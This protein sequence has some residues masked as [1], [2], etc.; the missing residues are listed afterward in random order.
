MITAVAALQRVDRVLAGIVCL[1]FA[2]LP[3]WVDARAFAVGDY[4]LHL[5]CRGS[6]GP[7]VVLDV[8]LGGSSLEWTLVVRQL[9]QTARVCTYDRAGYGRSDAGPLPRTSAR[10]AEELHRLLRRAG[11]NA[12][13]ILVGHSF[14]GYNM[15]LFARRYRDTVAGLVL[16]D[17]SHPRQVERFLAPPLNLQTAPSGAWGIVQFREP[18]AP[19]P[20]LPEGVR[21]RIF[22]RARSAKSRR[23]LGAELLSFRD[24]GRQ[25]EAASG[26]AN[27]PLIVITR[28]QM[29]G[30]A[31]P[32]RRLLERV[33]LELQ[34]E[35]AG[36]SAV[37]AHLVARLSGHHIH[38]EQPE[39]VRYA[40]ALLVKRYKVAS[41]QAKPATAADDEDERVTLEEVTWLR[42]TL[43]LYPDKL[44]AHPLAACTSAGG[45]VCAGTRNGAP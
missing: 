43:D 28:G 27:L 34:I 31:T 24:S 17:A 36:A 13:Y 41:G 30:E 25:L 12:P 38:I 20:A 33:W 19:H 7:I 10:I 21:K 5:T 40:I 26:L 16:I 39:L 29:E 22:A 8:G 15:Q 6:G 18:P 11:E 3:T 42:D 37:S 45:A 4:R 35:L 32:K 14:G 1:L 2:L 44:A 9:R 23:A